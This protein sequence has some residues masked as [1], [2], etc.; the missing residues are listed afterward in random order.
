MNHED[1]SPSVRPAGTYGA[2]APA[3]IVMQHSTGRSDSTSSA[4][5]VEIPNEL[6][7]QVMADTDAGRNIVRCKDS[8][9]LFRRLGI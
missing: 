6:T 1:M 2:A 4:N 3:A 9:D 8:E 7:R 5:I